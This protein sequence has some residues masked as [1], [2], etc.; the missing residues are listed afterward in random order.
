VIFGIWLQAAAQAATPLTAFNG[1]WTGRG[2]DRDTPFESAQAT[3]CRVTVKADPTHLAS[4]TVCDG[5]GGL[6]KRFQMAVSFSGDQFTGTAE[7]T[8]SVRGGASTRRAG[9]ISG[10]R[11]GDVANFTVHFAGL[12]PN[13]H[14]VLT[15]TSPTSYAMLVSVLGVTLTDVTF[16]RAGQ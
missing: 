3:H 14:V 1:A 5:E 16:H 8:S 7:Q 4:T 6:H 10:S 15:L 11:N 13:A 12:T 2:T 9:T